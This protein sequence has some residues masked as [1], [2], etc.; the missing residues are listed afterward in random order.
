MNRG[1]KVSF[2]GGETI[3]IVD[4]N[5]GDRKLMF[6]A[7][8]EHGYR[9]LEAHDANE[10]LQ[11]FRSQAGKIDLVLTDIVMPGMNGVELAECIRKMSPKT[12]IFFISGYKRK[13]AGE[14]GVESVDFIKKSDLPHLLRKVR[15]VLSR[16]YLPI[17]PTKVLRKDLPRGNISAAE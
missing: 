16:S 7:L 14:I 8:T 12:K 15:E 2:S 3:L 5:D 1:H 9:V 4:D 11:I 17:P 13:F 10:A 6:L